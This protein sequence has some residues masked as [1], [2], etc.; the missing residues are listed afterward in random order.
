MKQA[1]GFVRQSLKE[2]SWL[3]LGLMVS[4]GLVLGLMLGYWPMRSSQNNM[5]EQLNRIEQYLAAQQPPAP[6]PV[7]PDVHAPAHKMKA[8]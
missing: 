7:A 4:A 6:A 5:Q 3:M 8:K 1:A 2:V